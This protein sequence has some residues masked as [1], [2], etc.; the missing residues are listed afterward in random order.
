MKGIIYIIG[1]SIALMAFK[2]APKDFVT[3]SGSIKNQNSDSLCL[4]QRG[5]IKTIKLNADGTFLDT[6]KVETGNYIM[7][8]GK[9]RADLF[10]KN[11]YDLNIT[12]DANE[13]NETLSFKG[14]GAVANN[15]LAKNAVL[16]ESLIDIDVLVGLDEA[17]FNEKLNKNEAV[18]KE[19]LHSTKDLDSG[20]VATQ[21][22][23]IEALKPK[24]IS[25]YNQKRILLALNGQESPKFFDY[26]NHKGGTS[27]LDNFK[28]KY[29][30]IDL[31]ATWCAPCKREIPFLK[32][33][34]KQYHHKNIEFI[35]ISIDREDAY[36]SW[37]KMVADNAIGD[38]KEVHA[39]T[40]RPIWPQCLN[41]P[42]DTPRKPS[43]LDWDLWLGPAPQ[44]PYSPP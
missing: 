25:K 42:E 27:S 23:E 15:Y 32:E 39:W 22:K 6:L 38:I 33:I 31:W 3:L 8:D 43:G 40:N 19:L 5:I 26:E 44:R 29:V 41:R 36:E 13:F 14:V 11:G 20:F 2:Q 17:A 4:V 9:N 35:S 37:R 28:G 30:Y 18:L 34:E 21:E 24:L 16:K 10:L 7:F 1:F 12:I